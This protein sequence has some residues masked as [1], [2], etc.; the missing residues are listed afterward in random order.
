MSFINTGGLQLK[1]APH[2]LVLTL[3]ILFSILYGV[4]VLP[5]TVFIRHTCLIAGAL[6]SLPIIYLNWHL[7][8][9]RR[10]IP[11]AL[12]LLL[13]VWVSVHLWLIGTNYAM[14]LAEYTRI[15][16][17]I[18]IGLPFAIGLG[19]GLLSNSRS[20]A[21]T[22]IYWRIIFLGFLSPTLIYLFKY[23]VTSNATRWGVELSPF[24]LMSNDIAHPFGI[25]KVSY[26]FFCLPSVALAIGRLQSLIQS[27]SRYILA[28]IIY[29]SVLPITLINFRIEDTRN[30]F[31]YALIFVVI[32]LFGLWLGKS[33]QF[34]L[35]KLALTCL[36]IS[37]IAYLGYLGFKD[38]SRWNAFI[39]DAK[40]A[41]QVDKYNNWKYCGV[42]PHG[43]PINEFGSAVSSSNYDRIAWAV[44]ALRLIRDNP[45]GYGIM[46]LSFA[47]LGRLRWPD[48]S[49]L[50]QSH[51][52]W[53]DFS[54]GYGIPGA[55]LLLL[56]AILTWAYSKNTQ[57]PWNCIGR[58]VLGSM[59]LL[60]ITTE[61]SSEVFINA[62]IFLIVM[63]NTLS[64]QFHAEHN[65]S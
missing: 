26:V 20:A 54:L 38:N 44:V 15:W 53:L 58:W 50:H 24:L 32:G 48:A 17:K 22:K 7:F 59:I 31:A 28:Y 30:G 13:V 12:I 42:P 6:L 45:L 52:A 1:S 27:G 60:L 35:R 47:Y 41:I 62:F 2:V 21:K 11:I 36:L 51:S 63:A 14:Q 10:A 40:V 65:Q 8:L 33:R 4:W 49:C 18:V 19:L 9:Q 37:V 43:Y 56:A 46:D 39:P 3:C 61:I 5:H 64:L 29:L 16:K 34:I 57:Q 25:H 23:W 55:A